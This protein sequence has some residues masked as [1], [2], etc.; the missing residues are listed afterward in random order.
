VVNQTRMAKETIWPRKVRLIS[1][2]FPI[3]SGNALNR[4]S[5]QR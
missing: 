3:N 5:P 2:S 4:R 1:M